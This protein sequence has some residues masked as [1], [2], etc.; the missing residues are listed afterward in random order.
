MLWAIVAASFLG[1]MLPAGEVQARETR[2]D[3]VEVALE[4]LPHEARVTL[5][6]IHRGGPFPYRKDG[7]TFSNREQLLPRR[8]RGYYT[9]YTVPTP[10][11]RDRGARRIVVGGKEGRLDVFY[12]TDDHYASFRKIRNPA[13]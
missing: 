7:T 4:E 6:L 12:Y 10:R 5:G 9:E 13:P 1:L 11:A 8:P 3:V 2:P